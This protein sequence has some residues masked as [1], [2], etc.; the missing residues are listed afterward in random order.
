M[1]ARDGIE[2]FSITTRVATIWD[3]GLPLARR[4]AKAFAGVRAELRQYVR[5]FRT[6]KGTDMLIVPGTGLMTDAYGLAGWGPYNMFKWVLMAKLRRSSVLFVSV[7]AGPADRVVGRALVKAALSLADYR[8]Y[9]DEASR[10]YLRELGFQRRSD[11]V[12]PDLVFSLPEAML[13]ADASGT[14]RHTTSRRSRA[15][16]VRREVRRCRSRPETYTAYLES[17]A[18]FATMAPRSRLRHPTVARRQRR[19][20]WRIEEFRSVLQT[21][22]G[23]YGRSASS[24]AD[25]PRSRTYLPSSRRPT[26]SLRPASIT[27]S[28]P[29]SLTSPSSRSPS[30]TSAL[31]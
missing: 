24:A 8:S 13:P 5:A 31:P 16:V 21:R 10:D 14:G 6:L 11:R 26:S 27:F 7:G 20:I 3:R 22:P 2:A 28:S 17:L 15:D 30:I 18:D 4:V 19:T 23:S 1:V 29:C 9:R 25:R 12:Y